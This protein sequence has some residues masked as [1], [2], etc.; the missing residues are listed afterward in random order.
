M[1]KIAD[2]LESKLP[3]MAAIESID[4]GKSFGLACR[5]IGFGVELL[6]YYAGSTDK[7]HGQTYPMINFGQGEQFAFEKKH[8]VGVCG[9]IV[10][11][12]FPFLMSVFK[13]AP[14]LTTGCTTVL[15]PAELTPL[16]ALRFAEIMQESGL[17]AGVVNVVPGFGNVA[18]EA[19]V[20]HPDVEKIAFTGS[21]AVGKHILRSS[22]DTM[23]RVTLELG[24]KNAHIILEDADLDVAVISSRIG[25]FLNSGQFC[26]SA[27]RIFVHE[28]IHDKF[29]EKLVEVAR[30]IKIGD[31]F[32]EGVE[33]GP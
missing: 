10:P 25:A 17:P 26:M 7:L 13:I 18:G 21:T 2:N 30:A 23:K 3:E 32:E 5:D 8:P 6:R 1:L 31:P 9:Q 24:G 28:N 14:V 4:N 29:V 12:N 22:A 20:G 16:T 15:K 11:W 27:S 33:N 19:L